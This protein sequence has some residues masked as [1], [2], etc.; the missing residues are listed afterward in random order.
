[1]PTPDFVLEL[2]EKIGHAPLWLSGVTGVVV[3]DGDVLLVKRADTGAWTP[4]TGIIDPGEEP[5]IAAEREV[6]EEAGIVAEAEVLTWVHTI[7][8][9]TYPNGD[10]SQYL[11]IA[12]RM[13]YVSGH[14]HPADGE[15]TEAAWFALD[16]LPEMSDEMLARVRRSLVDGPA[17]F[18]R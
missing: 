10:Q 18:E 15:N 16:A 6:L 17:R 8:M 11:D 1:M 4:V 5:A 14:P 3:R 13:R 2:R 9:V 12:F 7:P